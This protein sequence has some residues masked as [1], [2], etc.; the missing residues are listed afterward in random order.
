MHTCPV[1]QHQIGSQGDRSSRSS[2]VPLQCLYRLSSNPGSCCFWLCAPRHHHLSLFLSLCTTLKIFIITCLFRVGSQSPLIL[3]SQCIDHI[4]HFLQSSVAF[5]VS[6]FFTTVNATI[7]GK[8]VP[9]LKLSSA[10]LTFVLLSKVHV[11]TRPHA[12]LVPRAINQS[13]S[14]LGLK[15]VL[16]R[17]ASPSEQ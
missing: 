7:F 17:K 2:K 5:F 3:S 9:N 12:S 14:H 1:L 4:F 13:G 10:S 15:G 11:R 8:A 16:G 6:Y